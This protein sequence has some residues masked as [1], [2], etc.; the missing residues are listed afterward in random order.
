VEKKK[1]NKVKQEDKEKKRNRL[2]EDEGNK[3][4]MAFL[5]GSH[6]FFFVSFKLFM[7]ILERKKEK[8]KWHF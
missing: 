8:V 4:L 5:T 7:K 2:K 3:D 1:K 6:Y